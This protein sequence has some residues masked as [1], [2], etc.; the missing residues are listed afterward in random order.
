MT[1]PDTPAIDRVDVV[2]GGDPSNPTI[3]VTPFWRGVDRPSAGGWEI[4]AS[5]RRLAERLSEAVR[6][7]AVHP[8]PRVETDA[9][10]L[11]YVASSCLV[12]GR[13]MDADLR[14]LG[15]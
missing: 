12:L 7:G 5:K 8:D 11:T 6:A 4:P 10:G 14:R 2:E 1:T 3:V 13:T 15:H 9:L